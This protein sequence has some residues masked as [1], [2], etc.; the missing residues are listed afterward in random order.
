MPE[1]TKEKQPEKKPI[2]KP[3]NCMNCNKQL[4][5]KSWYYRNQGYYCSKR[6]WKQAVAKKKEKPEK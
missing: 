3:D 4:Q 5:R 1:E 6:C 2:G